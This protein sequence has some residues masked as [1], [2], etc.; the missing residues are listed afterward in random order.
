MESRTRRVVLK[1]ME[2]LFGSRKTPAEMLK[3]HQR[4]LTK[5]SR[6]LDRERTKLEAQE[7]KLIIEI[8]KSAKNGQH[9][10][11]KIQAK[12]LVRTRRYVHNFY[13]MRTQL[14]AVGLKIQTLKSTAQMTEALKGV[15]KAMASMNK[16]VQ[17]PGIQKIMMDFTRESE[18]MD[19]KQ[20]ML[21]D[22][23]ED[24]M[25]FDGEEEETDEVLQKVLDE[26][27]VDLGEQFAAAPTAKLGNAAPS[28]RVAVAE[29]AGASDDELQA[30]LDQ[31]RK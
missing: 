28:Q 17:L 6:E 5:A 30:R 1:M 16:K 20:E 21:E 2:M 18:M 15:T 22:T 29:G 23:V 3:Q 13:Q 11:A 19:M 7:K 12:D 24:V 8:K 27:G 26:I 9:N 4:S 10:A 31:L 25:E 14:Q